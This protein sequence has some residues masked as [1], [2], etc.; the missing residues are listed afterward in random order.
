MTNIPNENVIDMYMHCGQCL[1]EKPPHLTPAEWSDT[2]AGW[3]ELGIQVWCNRHNYNIMH[4]DFEGTQHP[5]NT[6][7]PKPNAAL[8]LVKS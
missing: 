5:A 2:Q 3:T 7:C 8:T 6:T 4:V 1:K